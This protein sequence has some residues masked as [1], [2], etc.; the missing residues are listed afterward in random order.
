MEVLLYGRNRHDPLVSV[1]Q[2]NARLFRV[3]RLRFQQNY[4]CNNLEAISD[5]VLNFLKQYVLLSQ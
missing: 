2:M 1:V 4:A 3:H 5:T